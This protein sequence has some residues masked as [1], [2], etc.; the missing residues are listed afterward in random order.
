MDHVVAHRALPVE[1]QAAQQRGHG[2]AADGIALERAGPRA[3]PP[4]G[5]SRSVEAVGR[6]RVGVHPEELAQ[7]VLGQLLGL[8]RRQAVR[9]HGRR[10]R[11]GHAATAAATAQRIPRRRRPSSVTR[12]PSRATAG[13][14][15]G[16]A[17]RYLQTSTVAAA[18]AS[19]M[20]RASRQPGS[21]PRPPLTAINNLRSPRCAASPPPAGA[22]PHR[23]RPLGAPAGR[24]QGAARPPPHALRV[25]FF[26]AKTSV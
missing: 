1:D 21:S 7:A 26:R 25:F 14:P 8:P 15:R 11:A 23:R 17:Y 19:E 13:T 5:R 24:P 12:G 9:R 22:V 20:P 18:L 2:V 4:L 16:A 10:A 6:P 3:I